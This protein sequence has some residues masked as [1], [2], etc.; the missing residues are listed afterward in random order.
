M[1]SDEVLIASLGVVR[2]LCWSLS[3]EKSSRNWTNSET[4]S[5]PGTVL[6]DAWFVS[7][8]IKS[9]GLVT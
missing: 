5:T 1:K 3:V 7:L 8:G 9:D 6:G 4:K 2:I